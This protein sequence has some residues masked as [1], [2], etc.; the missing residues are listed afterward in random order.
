MK[1]LIKHY[2]TGVD[3]INKISK[4][5]LLPNE[6]I[7]KDAVYYLKPWYKDNTSYAYYK[8]NINNLYE[9]IYGETLFLSE[10]S[11]IIKLYHYYESIL[12]DEEKRYLLNIIK[13]FRSRVKYITKN[14]INDKLSYI[15][16]DFY[17][18]HGKRIE[19]ITLPNFKTNTM[20]RNMELGNDYTLDELGL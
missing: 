19:Y 20:Y 3:L 12:D 4:G 18:P 16:I 14:K 1:K 10:R 13:P 8:T 9:D 17:E 15:S 6:I 5:E 11:N 7:C 2:I